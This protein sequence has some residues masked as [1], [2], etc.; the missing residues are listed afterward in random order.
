M[1]SFTLVELRFITPSVRLVK[2]YL[3][4]MFKYIFLTNKYFTG[5]LKYKFTSLGL[6]YGAFNHQ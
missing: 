3:R 2:L 1:V 5:V 6:P 4:F